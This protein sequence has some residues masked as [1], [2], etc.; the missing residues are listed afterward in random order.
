VFNATFNNISAISW[1][2]VLLVHG[3]CMFT[4]LKNLV[5]TTLNPSI[6]GGNQRYIY[7]QLD[8]GLSLFLFC[9]ILFFY[10]FL[11]FPQFNGIL[12]CIFRALG[13]SYPVNCSHYVE[14]V[15]F[16]GA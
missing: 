13:V 9:F 10:F 1:R 16:I 4:L 5:R 7:I 15:S 11:F 6:G 2:S 3:L 8:F 12:N 14:L